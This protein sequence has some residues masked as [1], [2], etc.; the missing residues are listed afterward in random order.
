MIP[1]TDNIPSRSTPLMTYALIALNVLAFGIELRLGPIQLHSLIETWGFSPGRF[2][3]YWHSGLYVAAF[4]PVFT[5]MFLHAG[6]LHLGGNMLFLYVFGDN[7]EDR[8]GHLRFLGFYMVCGLVAAMV[9]SW[10]TPRGPGAM[11]GASG[12]IA[13]ILGGYFVLFPHARVLTLFPIFLIF[14]IV[15]LRAVWFLGIWIVV[16]MVNSSMAAGT[17]AALGGIA[18]MAHVSGFF[19]GLSLVGTFGGRR[20]PM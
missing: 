11:I 20:R 9:Q 18:W 14:P 5:S 17:H 10:A 6:W 2:R 19:A 16:Q 3:E 15:P 4:L 7:V 8:M 12:A 1:I 13:G